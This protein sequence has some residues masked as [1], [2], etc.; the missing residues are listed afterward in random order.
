MKYAQYHTTSKNEMDRQIH[1]D[2]ENIPRQS[3]KLKSKVQIAL[4]APIFF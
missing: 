3:V 4:R 1:T 2:K